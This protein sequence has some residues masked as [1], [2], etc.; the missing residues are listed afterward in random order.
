MDGSNPTGICAE[1]KL[2][3]TPVAMDGP[4]AGVD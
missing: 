4:Q 2:A 1:K 3:Y